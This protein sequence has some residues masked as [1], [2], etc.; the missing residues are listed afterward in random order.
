MAK[1][2][3]P[4]C[5]EILNRKWN[6][7]PHVEQ[8]HNMYIKRS[9]VNKFSTI[10]LRKRLLWNHERRVFYFGSY[11]YKDKEDWKTSFDSDIDENWLSECLHDEDDEEEQDKQD[12][13]SLNKRCKPILKYIR[14]HNLQLYFNSREAKLRCVD[15]YKVKKSEVEDNLEL[16]EILIDNRK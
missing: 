4:I 11:Q 14:K 9:D 7:K 12:K 15:G 8:K 13:I 6:V 2:E 3:C 10:E 5:F 1:F 16:L